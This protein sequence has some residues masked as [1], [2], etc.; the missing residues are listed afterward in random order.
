MTNIDSIQYCIREAQFHL[1]KAKEILEEAIVNPTRYRE[2]TTEN[3]RHMAPYLMC[4]MYSLVHREEL[5]ES[6]NSSQ[7]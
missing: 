2:E 7:S 6:Q 3:Y 1:D 4:M 5:A